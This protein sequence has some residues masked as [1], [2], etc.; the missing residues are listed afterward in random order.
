MNKDHIKDT[1]MRFNQNRMRVL[2]L[3]GLTGDQLNSMIFDYGIRYLEYECQGDDEGVRM[4]SQNG[5]YWRWWQNLW[6]QRDER[7]I[8]E[9][10]HFDLKFYRHWH[11]VTAITQ[12][13]H[14]FIYE[15]AYNSMIQQQIQSS[16]DTARE[17]NKSKA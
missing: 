5:L 13:P 15:Q 6:N 10:S 1:I 9:Y 16:H 17:K 11:N 7:L 8:A 14:R 3:A 2:E 12:H 4:M